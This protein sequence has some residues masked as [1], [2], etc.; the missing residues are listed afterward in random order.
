MLLLKASKMIDATSL[1]TFSSCENFTFPDDSVARELCYSGVVTQP[2]ECM[3]TSGVTYLCGDLP[4]ATYTFENE[5][6]GMEASIE[7]GYYN[8]TYNGSDLEVISNSIWLDTVI[9]DTMPYAGVRPNPTSTWTSG[10]CNATANGESCDTCIFCDDGSVEADC[11]N[12]ERGRKV[13]C[14]DIFVQNFTSSWY[15]FFPFLVEKAM[16]ST[17]EVG[18][19]A[20]KDMGCP[21]GEFCQL[22]EGVCNSKMGFHTGVCATI[23]TVCTMIYLPVW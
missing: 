6:E 21:G 9:S 1:F 20:D 19:D 7:W 23:P 13:E 8:D 2:V 18:P 14:G 11:T 12:I 4:K 5:Y 16:G 10:G 15:F 22:D 17:C 3:A